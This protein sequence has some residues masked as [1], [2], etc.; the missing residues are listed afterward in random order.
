MWRV[1]AGLGSVAE[2]VLSLMYKKEKVRIEEIQ[3]TLNLSKTTSYNVTSF[4][5][6]F[7][8]VEMDETNTHFQLSKVYKKFLKEI[9]H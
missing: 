3:S 4:L 2:E 7:G 1:G 9:D 5:V 8:F 6:Q